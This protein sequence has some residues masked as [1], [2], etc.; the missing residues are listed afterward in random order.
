MPVILL[1]DYQFGIHVYIQNSGLR[2]LEI[3]RVVVVGRKVAISYGV[4]TGQKDEDSTNAIFS[5][6]SIFKL[7][8]IQILNFEVYVIY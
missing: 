1:V 3:E 4:Y 5:V 2:F 7:L 8:S 6:L